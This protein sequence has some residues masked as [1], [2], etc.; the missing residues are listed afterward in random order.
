[1]P[2]KLKL[3]P[4][5]G[6]EPSVFKLDYGPGHGIGCRNWT[7]CVV[8]PQIHSHL[9]TIKELI[10]AWNTRTRTEKGVGDEV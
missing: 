6:A 2:E 1:M 10:T 9:M 8:N 4:F 7:G 5:C 3:C